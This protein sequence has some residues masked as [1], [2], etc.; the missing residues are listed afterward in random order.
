MRR[1]AFS[2]V[3]L[4]VSLVLL[5][6]GLAAFARAAAAVARLEGDARRRYRMAD[7]LRARIDSLAA[8]PCTSA[9]GTASADGI[10]ETWRA[11]SDGRQWTLTVRLGVV[12]RPALA[13]TESGVVPCRR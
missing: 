1:A 2:L 13:R 7:V 10:D 9:S 4:V 11:E 6:V 5:G 12:G 8:L 3:E